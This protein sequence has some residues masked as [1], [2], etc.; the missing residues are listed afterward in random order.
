M[1]FDPRY[2]WENGTA[3]LN[4][5]WSLRKADQVGDRV[6]LRG[7]P[8]VTNRGRMIIGR[9]VQLVSTIATL[10]LVADTQ[11]HRFVRDK[12]PGAV[13]DRVS[14]LAAYFFTAGP[15]SAAPNLNGSVRCRVE[16]KKLLCDSRT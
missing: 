14:S 11:M 15:I 5:R 10:E 8:A 3:V 1:A 12:Q 2:V 16:P 4:A 9:R 13:M 6:R 7:H